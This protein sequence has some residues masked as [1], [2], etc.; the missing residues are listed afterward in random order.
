MK[1]ILLTSIFPPDVGGPAIIAERLALIFTQKGIET[2]VLCLSNS[3]EGRKHN[4]PVLRINRNN[5]KIVLYSVYF[6][7]LLQLVPGTDVI[8]SLSA[9]PGMTFLPL[10]LAKIFKKRFII[11]PGGDFLWERDTEEGKINLSLREYYEKS[12]FLK[13]KFLYWLSNFIFKRTDLI[14]FPTLFLKTLYLSYYDIKKERTE[15][16]DYPFPEIKADFQKTIIK[17][18]QI[19]FAGRLVNFKNLSRL[20][21]A[22][23]KI[24][25]K[26][27]ILKIIGEG[28]QRRNLELK[29]KNLGLENEVFVKKPLPHTQ[30]L[31]E[32]KKSYFVVVP[33]IFEPGSF[34]ALECLK[35]KTPILFTREA[36]IYNV[37]KDKLIFIDPFNVDDIKEKIEFLLNED[38]WKNYLQ[39]I[40]QIDT[41][42]SWKEFALEHIKI[43][44][45]RLMKKS[46]LFIGVTNYNFEKPDSLAHLESKFLGLGKGMRVISLARGKPFYKKIWDSEFYLLPEGFFYWPLAS[47]VA[48]YLCLVKKIDTIVA[49]SC[50]MEGLVG[51]ILK[52]IFRK[53]LIIEAHGDW[54]EGPFLS[55]KRKLEFLE[56]KLV[57]VLANISF[58]KADKI[59]VISKYLMVK[60]KEIV[61]DKDY[62]LFPTFTNLDMF[63][64]ERNTRIDNFILFVG[65]L[66]EVKGVEYL[67]KAF[68]K[69]RVEFPEFKLVIIGDGSERKNLEFRVRELKI[70]DKVD[71]KGRLSLKETKNIMKNCYCFVLPSLSEGLGR[72]LMEAMALGKPVIGSNVG[73][74]PDLIKDNQNGFLFEPKNLENLVNKLEI[75][76]KDKKLAIRMG[77][78]GREFIEN[79]FSNE[80]YLQNFINI[81]KA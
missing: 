16:V 71:F 28:T 52:V 68:T 74:I 67:I 40:S 65:G 73:G 41:S 5:P 77:K 72:V 44:K 39:D 80:R 25:S 59:R 55:K 6:L 69:I 49:Q 21:D 9:S 66:E 58:K 12:E 64:E 42:R 11:R 27:V 60:A 26:E 15:F 53:E 35:L 62:F 37:F 30:L 47:L 1:I 13:K 32:I 48:F 46:V 4:F 20:I 45:E 70:E 38:N 51:S 7:K 56:R 76:L 63:L 14:I 75:L 29:I 78:N 79:N 18:K 57:P 34:L 3:K 81:I 54:V 61:P 23:S 33:S 10:I 19:L 36:G 2:K 8:Y 43:L 50:L 17:P 22:F 31:E 24:D